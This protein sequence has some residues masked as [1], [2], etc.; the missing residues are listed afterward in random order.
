LLLLW[1]CSIIW[2]QELWYLQHWTF[3][4]EFL[5]LFQVFCVSMC[6]LGLIFFISVKN[7]MNTEI[8]FGSMAIF[9]MLILPIHK[10][11]RSFHLLMSSLISLQW[12][13]V[14]IEKVFGFLH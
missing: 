5:W 6:I 14:F 10:H 11:G 9:I 2:N 3:W 13:V 8:A 1:L 7:V 4:S 12:C